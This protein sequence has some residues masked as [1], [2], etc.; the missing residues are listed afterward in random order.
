MDILNYIALGVG[1]LVFLWAKRK[2]WAKSD[3]Q[4]MHLRPGE[5]NDFTRG[6]DGYF[7]QKKAYVFYGIIIAIVVAV[8][9][10]VPWPYTPLFCG[11]TFA[12]WAGK[13]LLSIRTDIETLEEDLAAQ[14][15]ILAMIARDPDKARDYLGP[16]Q[17]KGYWIAP[18]SV[19]MY[20]NFYDFY[21]PIAG[22]EVKAGGEAYAKDY[23]RAEAILLPRLIALAKG[24]SNVWTMKDRA[25]RY[26]NG[27]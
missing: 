21:E 20:R 24:P 8:A 1:L 3:K 25:E 18:S 7:D 27:R 9:F 14:V 12:A 6:D 2:D 13:V 11:G 26:P 15:A 17:I 5:K 23:T 22:P 16:L 4:R 10:L 19:W